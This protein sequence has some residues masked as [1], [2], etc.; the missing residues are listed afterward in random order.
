M[1]KAK[2]H[3]G[4]N[5]L[6]SR[7]HLDLL[8]DKVKEFLAKTN[9]ESILEIGPGMGA[10]T[11]IIARNSHKYIECWEIDPEAI[12]FLINSYVID[13]IHLIQR[14]AIEYLN[15][16][17][18][19]SG[20]ITD[21]IL[22]YTQDDNIQPKTDEILKQVQDDT[23]EVQGDTIIE[24][25]IPVEASEPCRDTLTDFVLIS[26]LPYNVGSRVLIDLACLESVPLGFLV[27]L[28]KEVGQKLTAKEKNINMLGGFL[29]LF[30]NFKI[31][32]DFPRS[33]FS[34][35]PNVVSV[36]V[37]G[38]LK[39]DLKFDLQN[40]PNTKILETMKKLLI[41]PS[42]TLA[43][44]LKNLDWSKEQIEQFFEINKLDKNIRLEWGNY[45]MILGLVME[46]MI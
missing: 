30:Y 43:N 46:R 34:P 41:Y 25:V 36:L 40:Y 37:Q 15:Q 39:K 13:K 27:M 5:F 16:E 45:E 29:R 31:L 35:Q 12:E 19:K 14:D 1:I 7:Y 18:K 9:P 11:E 21:K 17:L 22:R 24:P 23:G 38:V 42:K 10:L 4:Q 26:N 28:Q 2:K 44:N 20:A 32:A 33:A 6:V 8:E 3:F